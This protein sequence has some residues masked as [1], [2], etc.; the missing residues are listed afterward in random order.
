VTTKEA[1]LRAL[2]GTVKGCNK[3]MFTC[4]PN[5]SHDAPT[6]AWDMIT[7]SKM[8]STIVMGLLQ[9][10]DLRQNPPA[11]PSKQRKGQ[12]DTKGGQQ[13][14]WPRPHRGGLTSSSFVSES[15]SGGF[16][17]TPSCGLASS[18]PGSPDMDFLG[19]SHETT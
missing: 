11:A 18:H 8:F 6:T 12:R 13:L 10:R 14:A 1:K 16:L 15:R 3:P 5:S 4:L 19:A 2:T 7:V 9:L 17:H